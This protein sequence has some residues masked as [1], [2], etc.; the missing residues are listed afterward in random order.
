MRNRIILNKNGTLTDLSSDLG[1]YH[2]GSGS[3]Y[4]AAS[5]DYL[6]IGQRYPFNHLFFK[7]GVANDEIATLSIDLWDGNTWN[8]VAEI[9]DTTD[10]F[11]TSGF[12]TWV[13]NKLKS[14]LRDDTVDS[15]GNEQITGF[16]TDTIIYDRYWMRISTDVTLKDT[17]ALSWIG[18]LFC[19]DDDIYA[20]YSQFS[21]SS[22][23]T[24]WETGKTTWEEQ[25]IIASDLVIDYMIDHNIINHSG[26]IIERELLRN[27][28][29]SRVAELI[30][31]PFG[32]DY[33]DDR[34]KAYKKFQDRMNKRL[35]VVD[36]N[37]NATVDVYETNIR[38]GTLYR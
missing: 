19:T 11:T 20:E 25:R 34:Q 27:A 35:F 7:S 13:P 5:T 32:D 2:S 23:L 4:L 12:I 17:T 38:T 9:I 33:E 18:N 28:C 15:S 1:Y 3:A 22:Y 30:F 24:G 6:Y 26:Q 16:G 36:Q 21:R 10:A 8:A 31:T 14:W 29:V 37:K